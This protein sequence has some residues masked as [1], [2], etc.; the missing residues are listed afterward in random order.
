MTFISHS[1][2]L[3]I[4]D[5]IRL[6]EYIVNNNNNN[7]SKNPIQPSIWGMCCIK[8]FIYHLLSEIGV[9]QCRKYRVQGND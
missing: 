8:S 7:N 6:S 9:V 1:K 4:R 3:S 5:S 2:S